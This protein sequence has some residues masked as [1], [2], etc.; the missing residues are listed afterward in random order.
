MHWRALIIVRLQIGP[1]ALYARSLSA[2]RHLAVVLQ[3]LGEVDVAI[4]PRPSS[5]SIV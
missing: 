3:V 5:R 2:I 4:P 1:R